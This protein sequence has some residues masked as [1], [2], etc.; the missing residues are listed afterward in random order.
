M[1]RGKSAA[2]RAN[3]IERQT[4][5]LEMRRDGFTYRKIGARLNIDHTQ[6]F[7]DVKNALASLAKERDEEAEH[8][9]DLELHR[10]DMLLEAL[11]PMTHVGN[12]IAVEKFLRVCESR[13]KLLGLD[14]PTKVS[15]EYDLSPAQLNRIA[16]MLVDAGE[17]SAGDTLEKLAQAYVE[18][19]RA[20]TGGG[21]AG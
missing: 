18:S 9:V 20:D 14:A 11:Y 8:L 19:A 1:A 15:L 21:E 3:I 5:A 2:E 10:L 16:K 12:P 4:K 13:R 17:P 7:K 6:A